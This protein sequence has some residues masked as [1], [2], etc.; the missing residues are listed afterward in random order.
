MKKF[1]GLRNEL[2]GVLE[3][4][5]TGINDYWGWTGRV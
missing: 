5:E 4:H 3:D 1:K 2:S